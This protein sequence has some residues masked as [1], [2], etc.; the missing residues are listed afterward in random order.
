MDAHARLR[1]GPAAAGHSASTRRCQVAPGVTE[2]W[3]ARSLIGD[4][5]GPET[6]E[7]WTQD[8]KSS[9]QSWLS[10]GDLGADFPS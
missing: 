5:R 4:F 2:Q 1:P 8:P 7:L 6:L 3:K 9:A 10:P